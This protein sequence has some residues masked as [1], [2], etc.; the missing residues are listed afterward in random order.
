MPFPL[1]III[2]EALDQGLPAIS[3]LNLNMKIILSAHRKQVITL[4]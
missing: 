4:T 3:L 2:P 1:N